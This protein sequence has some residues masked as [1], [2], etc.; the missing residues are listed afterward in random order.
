MSKMIIFKF[1]FLY[2]YIDF[3]TEEWEG[4]VLPIKYQSLVP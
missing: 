1:F 3:L 4:V 2:S